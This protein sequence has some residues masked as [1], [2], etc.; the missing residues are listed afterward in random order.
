MAPGE[1]VRQMKDVCPTCGKWM[2]FPKSHQCPPIFEVIDEDGG[3][4][5]EDPW[6]WAS[7]IY[8]RDPETAAE[9]WADENDCNGDYTIIRG[10]EAKISVR[11]ADGTITRW[12]VTG[13]SVPEYTARSADDD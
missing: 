1:P 7:K 4:G 9:K 2:M 10:N 12:I 11:A 5:D 3:Y 8:A 13:E 6:Q